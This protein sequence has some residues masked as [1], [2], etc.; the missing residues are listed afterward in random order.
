MKLRTCVS[1]TGRFVY[2]VHRPHFTADNFRE[3]TELTDL[4]ILPDGSRHRNTANFPTGK[5]REPAADWIFEI[6]NAFPFRGTTYIGKAWADARAG[7]T[8]AI[9]LPKAPDISY[10]R[11]HSDEHSATRGI[12]NLPRPLQLALAV[13]S[14][15]DRD[16]CC[17][18]HLACTFCM[19][20]QSNRPRGLAFEKDPAGGGMMRSQIP[21]FRL[22]IEVLEDILRREPRLAP[23]AEM[24]SDLYSRQHAF[25]LAYSHQVKITE[26]V[27]NAYFDAVRG[28]K[29]PEKS[30]LAVVED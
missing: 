21:S 27:Q 25:A 30:W 17:L 14:T 15:D 29:V 6:P 20:K 19:D 22:P 13:T 1:P 4:G 18:A 11:S 7:N 26:K 16:L 24:V 12:R 10:F 2:G 28:V 9:M 5:V 23:S 3:S 8:E